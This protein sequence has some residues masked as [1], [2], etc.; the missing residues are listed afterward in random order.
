MGISIADARLEDAPDIAR[1]YNDAVVN[2][3]A[4]FDTEP[5]SDQDQRKRLIEHGERY[6]VIVARGAG[7]VVGWA[8][9]T[10]WSDRCA[11]ADTAEL[12]VYVRSDERGHG[13]G[14]RLA[15]AVL[16][17]GRDVGLHTI[18]A[19]M[20]SENE[21]SLHIMAKLGFKEIGIMR[22]VGYKFDRRLDVTLMQLIY[23]EV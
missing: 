21:V 13:A 15:R 17:R 10:A 6:P 18:L 5:V 22:Q 7:G 3:V 9:L 1:I 20:E 4:T 19:R 16:D 12:S 23:D 14:Y 8:S 11:Y 2:T